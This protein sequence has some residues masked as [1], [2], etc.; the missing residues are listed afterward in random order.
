M[1]REIALP[2]TPPPNIQPI[3]IPGT[4]ENTQNNMTSIMTPGTIENQQYMAAAYQA[5]QGL[6]GNQNQQ[7]PFPQ[8]NWPQT[9]ANTQQPLSGNQ[10]YPQF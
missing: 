2:P 5:N 3:I 4:M 10:T 6:G 7:Q 1:K 8:R 9:F